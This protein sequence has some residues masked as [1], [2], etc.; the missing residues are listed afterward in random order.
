MRQLLQ[1][2]DIHAKLED[3]LD[4]IRKEYRSTGSTPQSL[5]DKI[6][7]IDEE[8]THMQKRTATKC[9]KNLNN[10]KPWSPEL[11]RTGRQLRFWNRAV[12]YY[13]HPNQNIRQGL[14]QIAKEN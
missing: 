4:N 8:F 14:Q 13:M 1:Q 2:N 12:R 11:K 9:G 10:S 6:N 7:A 3:V 5:V